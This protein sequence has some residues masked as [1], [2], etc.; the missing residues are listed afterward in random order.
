[1]VRSQPYTLWAGLIHFWLIYVLFS[2]KRLCCTVR[3][4]AVRFSTLY[5]MSTVWVTVRLCPNWV[6]LHCFVAACRGSVTCCWGFCVWLCCL[7]MLHGGAVSS[8]KATSELFTYCIH[9]NAHYD[10]KTMKLAPYVVHY[11]LKLWWLLK[12]NWARSLG[13]PNVCW[14]SQKALWITKKFM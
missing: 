9:Y 2:D 13:N 4:P 5:C 12:E 3:N 7:N 11:T 1:M 10:G 14:Q 6:N 8:P